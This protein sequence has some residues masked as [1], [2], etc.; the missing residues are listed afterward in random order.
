MFTVDF[1]GQKRAI[2]TVT[3]LAGVQKLEHFVMRAHLPIRKSEQLHL[4]NFLLSNLYS[5]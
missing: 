5:T 4:S 2:A 3:L 1:A